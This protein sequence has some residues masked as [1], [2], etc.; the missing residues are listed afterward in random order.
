MATLTRGYSFGAT[1]QVTNAKLHGLV[2]D[3]AVSNIATAD[4]QDAS[5][6]NDKIASCSGAKFISLASTPAGAGVIPAANLTSVAQ[7]GA[8]SDI[9]SLTGC[10]QITGMTTALT[11]VQGGTGSTAAANAASG[12]VVLD[13]SSKISAPQLGAWVNKS[14]SYGAQQAATDGFVCV[15]G[16]IGHVVSGYTDGSNPPE[17]IR[18]SSGD[19]SSPGSKHGFSMPVKKN[20][21]WKVETGAATPTI[22]W[23]PLGS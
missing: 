11:T 16:V 20:D 12:V 19:T 14:A 22:Y 13:A 9:T 1:E 15:S 21:Y 3:G 18:V 8:N 17:T 10:T 6:T 7:K 23:I 5:V 4:F 2:D